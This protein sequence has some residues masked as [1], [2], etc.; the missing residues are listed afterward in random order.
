MLSKTHELFEIAIKAAY[1]LGKAEEVYANANDKESQKELKQVRKNAAQTY[2][3][4][5]E[6]IT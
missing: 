5:I 4:F 1:E 6:H 3:D 2:M